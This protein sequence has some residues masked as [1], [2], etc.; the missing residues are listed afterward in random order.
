MPV[1]IGA[2][3]VAN[4]VLKST[5]GDT[6]VPTTTQP[7]QPI[8]LPTEPI[9]T[10]APTGATYQEGSP[11]YNPGYSIDNPGPATGSVTVNPPNPTDTTQGVVAQVSQ[12]QL[13]NLAGTS[14]LGPLYMYDNGS[15]TLTGTAP[16]TTTSTTSAADTTASQDQ[17]LQDALLSLLGTGNN[18]FGPG[19]VDESGTSAPASTAG[20]QDIQGAATTSS[21][22]GSGLTI[23]II[24]AL[25][26]IVGFVLY[27][28]HKKTGKWL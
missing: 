1:P 26:A 24:V 18:A 19:G 13:D 27:F 20:L 15:T 3:P 17:S 10:Q 12:Q 2:M 25:L 23:I 11:T 4:P 28:H 7:A 8:A 6:G 21:S 9:S 5:V 16:T 14:Q 22:S